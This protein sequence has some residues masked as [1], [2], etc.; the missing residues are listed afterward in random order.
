MIRSMGGSELET[1]LYKWEVQVLETQDSG[2]MTVEILEPDRRFSSTGHWT[3]AQA[4]APS[5][6]SDTQRQ[7]QKLR[8]RP[9]VLC[10][11]CPELRSAPCSFL[12]SAPVTRSGN[13]SQATR[14]A[15]TIIAG[16][17]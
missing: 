9:A 11:V 4:A 13:D 3:A 14:T 6:S 2:T 5:F 12:R 10:S 17:L 7:R 16:L 8:R 15:A 1:D